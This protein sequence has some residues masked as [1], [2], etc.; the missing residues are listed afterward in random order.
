MSI[1]PGIIGTGGSSGAI[2]NKQLQFSTGRQLL[3]SC[4]GFPRSHPESVRDGNA[5]H[6]SSVS[7]T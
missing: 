4:R 6:R 2:D 5:L 3:W 7:R 1:I